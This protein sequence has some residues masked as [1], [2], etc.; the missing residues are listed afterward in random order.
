MFK[1]VRP[2]LLGRG[3]RIARKFAEG[4]PSSTP[5]VAR[6]TPSQHYPKAVHAMEVYCK[7]RRVDRPQEAHPNHRLNSR[8]SACSHRGMETSPHYHRRHMLSLQ[9]FQARL[10]LFLNDIASFPHGTSVLLDSSTCAVLNGV[11]H[12]IGA[13]ISES[14]TL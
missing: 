7:T 9:R 1:Q 6:S 11:Y 13:L 5:I 12:Q 4:T 14:A 10:T 3:L 2:S 8:L